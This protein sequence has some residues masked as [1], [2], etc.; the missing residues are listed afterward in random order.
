MEFCKHQGLCGGCQYTHLSYKDEAT[1]KTLDLLEKLKDHEA[2]PPVEFLKWDEK[3][4]RTRTDVSFKNGIFGFYKKQDSELFALEKCEH[5]EPALQNAFEQLKS[6]SWPFKQASF[7]LR[8]AGPDFCKSALW[9]DAANV[10][11]KVMLEDLKFIKD[12]LARF[13]R[14]EV[15]QKHKQLVLTDRPR[16]VESEPESWWTTGSKEDEIELRSFIGAFTQPSPLYNRLIL[17]W[18][19]KVLEK[20]Q[21]HQII[22]FGCGSG[23]LTFTLSEKKRCV[24]ALENDSALVKAL[25]KSLETHSEWAP[26]VKVL[27]GDFHR[28][29]NIQSLLKTHLQERSFDVAFCNPPRSGLKDFAFQLAELKVDHI[30]YM[31]CFPESMAQDL[32][33]LS[34]QNFQ[35]QQ[36]AI[37]DQFPRSKHYEALVLLSK[38][39]STNIT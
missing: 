18:I 34:N 8:V 26:F 12:L 23:N 10:D 15:G 37:V 4:H 36:L 32:K 2:L 20:I 11:V 30:L 16:L 39:T 33:V 29:A 13:H 31:S 9:I 28:S 24:L 5:W 22:E 19:Q 7:R 1:V 25:N 3:G 6:L 14:I 35:I 21:A 17:N 27:Q 38:I